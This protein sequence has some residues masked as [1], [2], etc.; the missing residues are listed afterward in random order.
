[1][2]E[3]VRTY[4]A[5]GGAMDPAAVMQACARVGVA[6][7]HEQATLI[8]AHVDMVYEANER[9]NLTRVPWEAAAQVHV[10]DSLSG[11]LEMQESPPGPWADIGSGAGF[12]GIPLCVMS[13]RH[14]DLVE[15][16]GKKAAVLST[17]AEHLCLDASILGCRAEEAAES[18]PARWSAVSARAVAPLAALVELS[19]PML[20]EGGILVCWKGALTRA[21]NEAGDRAGGLVGMTSM[22]ARGFL[23][24]G[25]AERVIAVYRKTGQPSLRL[26]RR[27]GS[28]QHAPLG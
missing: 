2:K 8:S 20:M 1:V 28:A 26:P 11:L 7:D 16:V 9:M 13:G 15:S 10:A 6:V 3:P 14:V 5:A 21:E 23:M 22:S 18:S 17:V 4:G 19:A 12:P 27:P 24:D 25:G